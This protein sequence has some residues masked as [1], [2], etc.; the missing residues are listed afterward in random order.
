MCELM[1]GE[2]KCG[3]K[4][5]YTACA[6]SASGF[7]WSVVT[8]KKEEKEKKLHAYIAEP[9]CRQ[10]PANQCAASVVM[11]SISSKHELNILIFTTGVQTCIRK[12]V[13]MWS[14]SS[15]HELNILIFTTGVQT[16]IRNHCAVRSQRINVQHHHVDTYVS[17]RQHTSAYVSISQHTSAYVSI[18]IR[19]HTSAYVSELMCSIIT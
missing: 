4:Q 3:E 16:C 10:E 8:K 6:V 14:I 5:N 15:K 2:K 19:Q 13:V 9:L 11:W 1:R 7:M 18:R 12:S 17:M